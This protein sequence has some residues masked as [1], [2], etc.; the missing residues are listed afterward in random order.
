MAQPALGVTVMTN[1][2]QAGELNC[3]VANSEGCDKFCSFLGLNLDRDHRN[4]D[5]IPSTDAKFP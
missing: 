5:M 4:N 1:Q 2:I 3:S